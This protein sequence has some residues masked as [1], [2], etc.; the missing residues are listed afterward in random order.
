MTA[1]HRVNSRAK[2]KRGELAFAKTLTEFGFPAYR[3]QQ[4]K[5]GEDSPDVICPSLPFLHWEV[6]IYAECQMTRPTQLLEW[7]AQARRDAGPVRLPVIA[8]KWA[9]SVWWVR[10]LLPE[11]RPVWLTLTD[12]LAELERWTVTT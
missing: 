10:V 3:G 5:G 8:H 7:D 1:K 12:F 11:R 9:R 6:K 4:N 2:G